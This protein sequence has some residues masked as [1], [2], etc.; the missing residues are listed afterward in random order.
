MKEEIVIKKGSV[1][2]TDSSKDLWR[3]LFVRVLKIF[4]FKNAKKT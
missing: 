1:E 2:T 4:L 3:T